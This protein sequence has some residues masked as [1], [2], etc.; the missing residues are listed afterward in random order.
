MTTKDQGQKYA[1]LFFDGLGTRV[2]REPENLTALKFKLGSQ[3]M[4]VFRVRYK[5]RE[6]CDGHCKF[7]NA[8]MDLSNQRYTTQVS[9]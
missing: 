3:Q 5:P 6:N 9:E 8:A 7:L 4:P 2:G 1:T